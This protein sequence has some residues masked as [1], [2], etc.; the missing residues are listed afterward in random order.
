M[1]MTHAATTCFGYCNIFFVDLL[2]QITQKLQLVQ[3]ITACLLG[4]E[5]TA[6]I[7]PYTLVIVLVANSFLNPIQSAHLN[8]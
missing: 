4:K 1:I 2:L 8:L 5:A 3:N 7:I 6:A